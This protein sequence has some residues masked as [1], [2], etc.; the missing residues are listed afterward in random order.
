MSE[1][2]VLDD[3]TIDKI[4]AGEVIER[5]A[6]VV[7]ELVENAIDAGA[8][9]VS[10]EIKNG[11]SDFIRVTDNGSGI[12]GNQVRTAFLP[13]AT[14]KLRKI[15]DLENL[16]SLG[17]RGE[18]LPSIAAVAQVELMTKTADALTGY[19]YCIDGGTEQSLDEVGVPDG[20]TFV[21]RNLFYHTPAR[22]KFL[23]TAMTEAGYVTELVEEMALARPDIA[24]KYIVNNNNKLVTTGNGELKDVVYRI[25]GRDITEALLEIEREEDGMTV[26]GYIAKPVI[27]RSSRGMEN[28][29]VNGRYVK[30]KVV[31]KAI[32]DAYAGFLM[33][34]K[35]PFVVLNI[36]VPPELLDVN[37]HPRKMEVKFGESETV[38]DFLRNAVKE[39]LS[40]K[41]FINN[42]TF[43]TQKQ[44]VA[45]V[46][47]KAAPEP[48]EK[49]RFD[50]LMQRHPVATGKAVLNA[51]SEVAKRV[52]ADMKAAERPEPVRYDAPIKHE[53]VV[54]KEPEIRSTPQIP[55]EP[56]VEKTVEEVPV[57][58]AAKEIKIEN[59]QQ[60]NL[61]EEKILTRT[62]AQ[63][64]TIVGQI[65]DTYWI[66]QY[67]DTML[68][69]DQHAAH[70]KVNYENF[71][72]KFEKREVTKQICSP[73]VIVTLDGAHQRIL[74][75]HLE[76]F[77]EMGFEIESFGGND[78]AIR[79]V[80]EDLYG[81]T[82]N[83]VFISLL[84]ELSD[85]VKAGEVS[86]IHD[87][88]A[89]MSCKAAVKGNMRLSVKEAEVL[90]ERLLELKDP[91]NCPHGRPTII[92]M[93]KYELEKK[94]K[95]IL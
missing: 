23:K 34:H 49:K 88:I 43:G 71:M 33:Q 62:A 12:P 69:I 76:H 35:F 16:S 51:A 31:A 8:T 59:P 52:D 10:I 84:D 30:D 14:S 28:Y 5:P 27:A 41:E 32:E 22:K 37:V 6:S 7:K 53:N 66:V 56:K 91:Y 17:F 89:S 86:V 80:P 70:E 93:T 83:E 9:S 46:V 74:E 20:T 26:H 61:F 81:L 92:K 21:V 64:F 39:T 47:P 63:E 75:K 54:L 67:R 3:R 25:F 58:Q 2:R 4:A 50:A 24:F 95:R 13:H 19:R 68:V 85:G 48:F 36:N 1:I 38:Y 55:D 29:F 87:K 60:L 11:G 78:Y 44:S 40:G 72:E 42:F 94:F 77:E 82:E 45:P 57:K 15:E 90:I 79:A 18:A 73:P 65:F